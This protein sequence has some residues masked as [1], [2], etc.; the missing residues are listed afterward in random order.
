MRKPIGLVFWPRGSVVAED[1][2]D[3]AVALDDWASGTASLRNEALEG[4]GGLSKGARNP[5]G[6]GL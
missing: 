4:S 6:L 2:L 5:E 3:V 1:D